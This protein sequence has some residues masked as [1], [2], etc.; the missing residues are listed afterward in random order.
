MIAVEEAGRLSADPHAN[1]EHIGLLAGLFCLSPIPPAPRILIGLIWKGLRRT[2]GKT[3]TRGNIPQRNVPD[4]GRERR[5]PLAPPLP[6]AAAEVRAT[7]TPSLPS[8]KK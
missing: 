2:L 8:R 6:P 4:S 3:G 5:A 1:V 7:S